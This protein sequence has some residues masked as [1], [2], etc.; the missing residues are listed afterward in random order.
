[1]TLLGRLWSF[2]LTIGIA[3]GL[4]TAVVVWNFLWYS[5]DFIIG[6]SLIAFLKIGFTT[7]GISWF[8]KAENGATK[9]LQRFAFG[10]L[11]SISAVLTF[12]I[13]ISL[14]EMDF[15]PGEA[16]AGLLFAGVLIQSP[17]DALIPLFF[18]SK[19]KDSTDENLLDDVELK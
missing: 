18:K 5:T 6:F 11:N 15:P 13:S 1:M 2:G 8:H 4:A 12:I 19:I 17:A 3:F 16:F 7:V 10:I 14:Y 9:Y